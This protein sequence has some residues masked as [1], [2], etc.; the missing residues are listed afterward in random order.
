MF[1]SKREDVIK[2]QTIEYE[3]LMKERVELEVHGESSKLHL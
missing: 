2:E 3:K 1:L